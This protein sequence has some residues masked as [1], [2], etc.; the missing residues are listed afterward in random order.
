MVRKDQA[1]GLEGK[2][3]CFA[4]CWARLVKAQTV[5]DNHHLF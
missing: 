5:N 3:E 4:G 1:A 2:D